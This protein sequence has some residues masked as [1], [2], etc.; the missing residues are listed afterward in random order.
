MLHSMSTR[1]HLFCDRDVKW[2]TNT[3]LNIMDLSLPVSTFPRHMAIGQWEDEHVCVPSFS[4]GAIWQHKSQSKSNKWTIVSAQP[5]IFHSVFFPFFGLKKFF[6][7]SPVT[8]TCLIVCKIKTYRCFCYLTNTL[9]SIY[10]TW[11]RLYCEKFAD[12]SLFN[13]LWILTDQQQNILW[14]LVATNGLLFSTA[15][16]MQ[17]CQPASHNEK[18]LK[19]AP[20]RWGNLGEFSD[21]RIKH[22]NGD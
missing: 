1:W 12:Q 8:S 3:I 2:K 11:R 9:D 16:H 4:T 14:R 15:N 21:K 18:V 7:L 10:S 5:W 6:I 19:L 20:L 22:N 13:C 17:P